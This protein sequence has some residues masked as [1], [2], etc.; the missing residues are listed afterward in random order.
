VPKPLL[1]ALDQGGHA[2]RALLF[3]GSG[4]QVFEASAPVRLL[5]PGTDRAEYDPAELLESLRKPLLEALEHASGRITAIGLATQRSNVACWD[6][7]S[8]EAKGPVLGWQ[9]RRGRALVEGLRPWAE[10]IKQRSGLV[11]TP[12]YGA[13]K[14]R[15]CLEEMG[16]EI[17]FGPMAAWLAARLTGQVPERTDP[18]NAQRTQLMNVRTL[19]WDPFLLER[20]GISRAHLPAIGT[21]TDHVG[22]VGGVPLTLVTGDQQAALFA[23]GEL[24][25]HTAYVNAGT[26]AFVL[27]YTGAR[28]VEHPRLLTGVL[29]VD[30]KRE[31]LIEGTVNGAGAALAWFQQQ[32][33][34]KDLFKKLPGWLETIEPAPVLFLNTVNGLGSP[35]WTEGPKPG[36]VGEGSVAERAVAVVESVV[37]LIQENLQALAE[38]LPPPERIRLTGGLARLDGLAQ[39]LADLSG[40]PVERPHNFEATAR[41]TAFLLAGRPAGWETPIKRF[42]PRK[43]PALNAAYARWQKALAAQLP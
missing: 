7:T 16:P 13:S 17:H 10:E 11:L 27:R 28:L 12:Y 4:E 29:H 32:F 33:G 24:D 26:G 43:N 20:F 3:D 37:F 1:L 19:D 18:V 41:G 30:E 40:L 25:E 14:L 39:R 9:D 22:E 35:F 6:P 2:S 23:H 21:N 31:Y 42:L 34:V 8:G 15:F 36:F 5:T 38:V